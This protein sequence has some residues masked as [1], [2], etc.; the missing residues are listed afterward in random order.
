MIILLHFQFCIFR[1]HPVGIS[2][3]LQG[4]H[5]WLA[6]NKASIDIDIE[7]RFSF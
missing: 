3:S 6:K 1:L 7:L 5:L 4:N 2:C